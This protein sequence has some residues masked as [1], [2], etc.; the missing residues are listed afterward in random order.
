MG[1]LGPIH[2]VGRRCG[3]YPL[4][5][6]NVNGPTSYIFAHKEVP[7]SRDWRCPGLGVLTTSSP[8]QVD[9]A[10]DPHGGLLMGHFGQPMPHTRNIPLHQHISARTLVIL[11]L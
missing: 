2:L 3:E 7:D 5:Q 4:V 1:V 6:D 8:D 9:R 10:E 11:G